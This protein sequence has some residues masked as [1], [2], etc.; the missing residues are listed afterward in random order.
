M[1]PKIRLE[2][3]R[4]TGNETVR[5]DIYIDERTCIEVKCSV[6]KMTEK[7]LGKQIKADMVNYR[8]EILY[9]YIYDMNKIIKNA[10]NFKE[11]YEK[12]IKEKRIYIIITQPKLL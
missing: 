2:V 9:F 3:T 8:Q 10:V 6:G 4:D 11:T 7:I 5:E 12:M 1:F